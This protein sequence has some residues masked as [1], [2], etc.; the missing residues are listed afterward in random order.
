[1]RHLVADFEI[2]DNLC[3]HAERNKF[4]IT[5]YIYLICKYYMY[6]RIIVTINTLTCVEDEDVCKRNFIKE[7]S[8]VRNLSGRQNTNKNAAFILVLI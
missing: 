2:Q 6:L 3:S 1:M 5:I 7:W 4:D 8:E